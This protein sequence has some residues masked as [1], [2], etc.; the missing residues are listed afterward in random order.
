[1]SHAPIELTEE[2]RECLN[3]LPP[4]RKRPVI[5]RKSWVAEDLA[6]RGLTIAKKVPYLNYPLFTLTRRGE[7]AIRQK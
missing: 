4:F 5:A 6:S 2:E 7:R 1:M 3:S